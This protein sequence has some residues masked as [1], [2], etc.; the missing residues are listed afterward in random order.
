MP[1]VDAEVWEVVGGERSADALGEAIEAEH[2]GAGVAFGPDV[3]MHRVEM[4]N[5]K[6]IDATIETFEMEGV[7]FPADGTVAGALFAREMKF[8]G[9]DG[10]RTSS[11]NPD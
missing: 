10:Q 4:A 3:V 11:N 9:H 1:T 2:A 6:G 8:A 7:E 5:G